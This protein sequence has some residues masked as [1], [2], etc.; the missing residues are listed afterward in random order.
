MKGGSKIIRLK[1]GVAS[2]IIMAQST[3]GT[4]MKTNSMAQ[5]WKPGSMV[6]NMMVCLH[7]A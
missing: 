2:S 4:G 7:M 5:E 3:M 6:P 1:A